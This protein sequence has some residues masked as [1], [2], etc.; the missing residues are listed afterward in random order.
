[1]LMKNNRLRIQARFICAIK[2]PLILLALAALGAMTTQA[3]TLFS[4]LSP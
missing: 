3:Q 4:E 1:M 2:I